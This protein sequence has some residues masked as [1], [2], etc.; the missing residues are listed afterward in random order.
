MDGWMDGWMDRKVERTAQAED[1]I[2]GLHWRTTLYNLMVLV[3]R[4]LRAV[5]A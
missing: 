4:M 1:Y 2:G 3:Y 5:R